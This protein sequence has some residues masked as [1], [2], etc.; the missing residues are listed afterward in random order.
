MY[1]ELPSS[2]WLVVKLF[3]SNPL[4]K[5]RRLAARRLQSLEV[6]EGR[7]FSSALLSLGR[8]IPHPFHVRRLCS[9]TVCSFLPPLPS[10]LPYSGLHRSHHPP[11]SVA[12]VFS[13]PRCFPHW[14]GLSKALALT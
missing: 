6:P 14:P 4:T 13:V 2:G 3:V 1:I 10:R 9:T 7:A 12:S 5:I 8:L 11:F